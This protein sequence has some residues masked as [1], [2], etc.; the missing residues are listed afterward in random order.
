MDADVI[1]V[2][3]DG[4]L[5]E[6]GDHGELMALHGTYDELVVNQAASPADPAALMGT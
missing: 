1:L 5:V 2:M 4:R 3:D 6:R